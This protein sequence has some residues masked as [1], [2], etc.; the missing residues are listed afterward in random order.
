VQI[1]WTT[2]AGRSTVD[3]KEVEKLLGFVPKKSGPE[4][5]RLSIKQ[6]GGK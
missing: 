5:N 1:S 4:S 6:S 3:D 2:V